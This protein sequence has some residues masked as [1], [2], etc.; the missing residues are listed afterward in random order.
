MPRKSK[1]ELATVSVLNPTDRRLKP[2][3]GMGARQKEI[4]ADVVNSQDAD[5]FTPPAI[6]LLRAYCDACAVYERL[7]K[8]VNNVRFH[9]DLDVLLKMIDRE[10]KKMTMLSTKMR[11][12]NQSRYQANQA[13]GKKYNR[14]Q[15]GKRPWEK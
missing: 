13:G 14:Q 8:D 5:W 3:T 11:L 4:W 1:A 12:T 2:P 9:Q 6:S 15:G 7:W 10:V